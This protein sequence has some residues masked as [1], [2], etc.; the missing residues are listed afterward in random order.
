MMPTHL[1][2]IHIF[3]FERISFDHPLKS[4]SAGSLIIDN[5]SWFFRIFLIKNLYFWS[6]N[7]LLSKMSITIVACVKNWPRKSD[8]W[9]QGFFLKSILT[10]FHRWSLISNQWSL[11]TDHWSL[12]NDQMINDQWSMINDQ[13]SIINNRS[14]TIDQWSMTIDH[15]SMTIDQWS[16]IID[17][18]SLIND[19]WSMI[20]DRRGQGTRDKGIVI[21]K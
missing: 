18:W 4:P 11:I 2:S 7:P 21:L 10:L 5:W 19:Q 17:H 15:W 20:I 13:W 1:P 9:T 6:F 8:F 3:V 14:M 12:I 16:L